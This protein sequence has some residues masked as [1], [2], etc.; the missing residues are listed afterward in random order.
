MESEMVKELGKEDC[1]DKS[2]YNKLVDDAVEA[3]SQYG[4]F[5]QFVSDD[6]VAPYF[7]PDEPFHIRPCGKSKYETCF[8]CP[9][10]KIDRFLDQGSPEPCTRGFDTSNEV[11][12]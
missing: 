12:F 2:Y 8:D 4:D 9:E 1:I 7:A 10:F 3:I 11:P 5:E 6:P